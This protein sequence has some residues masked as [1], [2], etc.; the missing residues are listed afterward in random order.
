M[1]QIVVRQ[2]EERVKDGLKRRAAAH[3]RS[4]EEEVR[5]ILSNAV[6]ESDQPRK[7]LGSRIADRFRGLG[8]QADLPELHGQEAEAVRLER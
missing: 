8:L 1:A 2:L 7:R 5:E 3:G 4:M 6:R